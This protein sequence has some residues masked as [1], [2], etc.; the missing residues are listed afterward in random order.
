[1]AI[2]G[3]YNGVSIL[4]LP[5]TPAPKQIQLTMNNI[6]AAPTNPFSGSTLQV[7]AWPGGDYWSGQIALPR[8]LP[9][10]QIATW[11]AFLAECRGKLNTFLLGD[12]SYKG[13]CGHVQ[14]IPVVDGAQQPMATTLNTRGWTPNCFRLLLPGDYLQVGYRLHRV[15]EPVNSDA[16]GKATISL[17]PSL[18][19]P[20]TDGQQITLNKPVGLFRMADNKQSVT[21]DET[22]LGAVSFNVVEA[23]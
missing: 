20:L 17:W 13:P 1:M 2:I 22:H 7:L 19:D 15:L 3:T 12:S 9:G 10:V 6:V 4:A 18:R 14:G 21:I 11:A 5:N 23:R 16:N 8:L